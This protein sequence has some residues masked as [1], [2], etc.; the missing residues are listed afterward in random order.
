[1]VQDN[2]NHCFLVID[3]EATCWQGEETEKYRGQNEIIEI[4][5]AIVNKSREICWKG[6]WFVRP[7]LHPVLSN[8]CKELTTIGQEDVDNAAPLPDVLALFS[9]KVFEITAGGLDQS[10]LVSWGNY[11]RN[12]FK[13]D[14]EQH[15]IEYPF[16]KHLNIKEEFMKKHG[17]KRCGLQKALLKLGLDYEGVPH[18][19]ADDAYNIARILI[20]DFNFN[21]DGCLS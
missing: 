3:L 4:G 5:A 6:G 9:A 13:K 12:Q 14:C 17:M 20:K 16:G 11:D 19:G 2:L 10:L 7:V 18:R 8:F 1:M 21:L 15:R